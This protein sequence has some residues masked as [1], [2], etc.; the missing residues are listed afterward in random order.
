[1]EFVEQFIGIIFMLLLLAGIV[2][3]FFYCLRHRHRIERWINNY[4]AKDSI[5]EKND[6]IVHHRRN[7]EDAEAKLAE[8]TENDLTEE[9]VEEIMEQASAEE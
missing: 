1:M 2:F 3:V 9:D 6:L 4:D 7:I 8:L 5:H